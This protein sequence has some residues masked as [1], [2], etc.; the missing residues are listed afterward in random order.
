M[1]KIGFCTFLY[2][3]LSCCWVLIHRMVDARQVEVGQILHLVYVLLAFPQTV[4]LW[5]TIKLLDVSVNR[6]DEFEM[7]V[8]CHIFYL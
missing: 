4:V 3:V 2:L 8:M 1:L 6:Q 7:I 5:D